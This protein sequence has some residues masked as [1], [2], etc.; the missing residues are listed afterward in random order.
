VIKLQTIEPGTL[1]MHKATKQIR[2]VIQCNC[3]QYPSNWQVWEILSLGS[4][5]LREMSDEVTNFKQQWQ[6][7]TSPTLEF[8]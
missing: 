1:I 3:Y 2:L 8:T 6:I 4:D 7:L 5:N